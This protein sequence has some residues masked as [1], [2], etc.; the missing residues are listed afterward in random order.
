MSCFVYQRSCY[1]SYYLWKRLCYKSF[2]RGYVNYHFK[3]AV[4]TIIFTSERDHV[5]YYNPETM[6]FMI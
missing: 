4:L 3:E 6:L 1:K 5:K 2:Y